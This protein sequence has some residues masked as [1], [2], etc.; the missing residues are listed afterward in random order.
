MIIRDISENLLKRF[1][2]LRLIDKYDIYQHL[3]TY[4]TDTMQD[5]VYTLVADG[6]NA[7]RIVESQEKKKEWDG[8]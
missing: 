7:G 6:W 3:M 1:A 4:W 2:G 8:F 5:D